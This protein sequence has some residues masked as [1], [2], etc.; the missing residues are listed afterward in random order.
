MIGDRTVATSAL[1]LI[2]FAGMSALNPKA[3]AAQEPLSW[4][5][6]ELLFET[7]SIGAVDPATGES[8][9]AVTTRRPCVGNG[10]PWVRAGVGAVATQASTRVAYGDELL[11]LLE[12]GVAPERALRDAMASDSLAE[13]RQVA[14]ISLDGRSAQHTG[15]RT[16]PWTG[17]RAGPN[18][19]TQG[20]GLVGAQVIAAVAA[21]FEASAGSGRHLG[22]RLIEALEAGQFAGGDQRKGRIQSA[23]VR[24]ADPRAGFSRRPDGVTTFIS[25]CEHTTPVREVRRIYNTVSETLGF[26]P[27]QRFDGGDIRQ[28]R[29]ILQALSLVPLDLTAGAEGFDEYDRAMMD[30]IDDFRRSEGLAVFPRSPAGMVDEETVEHLWAAVERAGKTEEVRALVQDIARVRR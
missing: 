12:R 1:L 2:V 10:V 29:I 11:D 5:G 18:Y 28:L 3:S 21:S 13:R 9:V 16:N 25:V 17:H 26:R 8:G 7:F 15:S 27:L 23:A 6:R 20:N 19:V 4:R 30:A 22:D 14:V 24:V